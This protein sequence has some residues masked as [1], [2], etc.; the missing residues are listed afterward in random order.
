M[1]KNTITGFILMA[2][3]LIGFTWYSRPSEEQIK[4]QHVRDSIAAV[5]REEAQKAEAAQKAAAEASAS[6]KAL[7]TPD[8]ASILFAA[9]QGT[10]QRV[11]LENDLVK[12]TINTHGGVIE[13]AELK[14]HKD[15]LVKTFT[16]SPDHLE[17]RSPTSLEP[18]TDFVEDNFSMDMGGGDGVG[19]EWF[20]L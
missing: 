7:A 14:N 13:E 12:I 2:L 6:A 8:S 9:S 1:D 10:E 20:R 18:R 3:V 11:T 4:A 15:H 19:Y 5:Q 17:Q 16:Q